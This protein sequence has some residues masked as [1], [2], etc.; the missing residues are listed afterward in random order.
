MQELPVHL[1]EGPRAAAGSHLPQKHR[2]DVDKL[3]ARFESDIL[4][5]GIAGGAQKAI[6]TNEDSIMR[7]M[8]RH[9]HRRAQKRLAARAL[10]LTPSNPQLET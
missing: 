8:F 9:V 2:D 1:Q 7:E 10:Q 6:Y 5:K 3:R 4:F